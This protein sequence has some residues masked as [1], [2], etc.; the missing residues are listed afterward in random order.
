MLGGLMSA[1]GKKGAKSS[2]SAGGKGDSSGANTIFETYT[3]VRK[4]STASL[5][6]A[7]FL[8]PAGYTKVQ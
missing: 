7:D 8:P 3:E 5:P 2:G 6:D 4:I 1:F